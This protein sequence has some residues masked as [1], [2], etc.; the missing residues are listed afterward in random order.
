MLMHLQIP[1]N[2]SDQPIDLMLDDEYV[3]DFNIDESEL[4]ETLDDSILNSYRAIW[5]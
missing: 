5:S 1:S 2:L 4:L 3:C